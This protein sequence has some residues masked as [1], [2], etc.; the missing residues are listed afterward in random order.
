ML[1]GDSSNGYYR[2]G[3][4]R[5]VLY[6]PDEAAPVIF[7]VSSIGGGRAVLR[8]WRLLLGNYGL[9]GDEYDL[10]LTDGGPTFRKAMTVPLSMFYGA[11]RLVQPGQIAIGVLRRP[12][13]EGLD[14]YLKAETYQTFF[15]VDSGGTD[16]NRI[17]LGSLPP[18]DVYQEIPVEGYVERLPLG[19]V[20]S[21]FGNNASTAKKVLRHKLVFSFFSEFATLG[22]RT[23]RNENSVP[24]GRMIDDLQKMYKKG[25]LPG[26]RGAKEN[27]EPYD[28]YDATFKAYPMDRWFDILEPISLPMVDFSELG[29]GAIQIGYTLFDVDPTRIQFDLS[30]PMDNLPLLR[31]SGTL[32]ITKPETVRRWNLTAIFAGDDINTTLV[33]LLRQID[34]CPALPVWNSAFHRAGID[35]VVVE[36]VQVQTVEGYPNAVQVMLGGIEFHLPNSNLTPSYPFWMGFNW[37]LFKLYTDYMPRFAPMDMPWTGE[38]VFKVPSLRYVRQ[39]ANELRRKLMVNE[40]L[41]LEIATAKTGVDPQFH[42]ELLA[43][44]S[45]RGEA[46]LLPLEGG[47]KY[48]AW[49]A[50]SPD[51]FRYSILNAVQP[52]DVTVEP[53]PGFGRVFVRKREGNTISTEPL[54]P[55]QVSKLVQEFESV[56]QQSQMQRDS[57]ARAQANDR[58]RQLMGDYV[59]TLPETDTGPPVLSQLY[60]TLQRLAAQHAP[61]RKPEGSASPELESGEEEAES[62]KYER[63]ELDGVTVQGISCGFTNVVA[64]IE[65][66]AGGI[67]HQFLGHGDT[68]AV[69]TGVALPHGVRRL[70]Q[71]V[72]GYRA[73][74]FAFRGYGILSRLDVRL[75]AENELLRMMGIESVIPVDL[76]L[77]TMEGIPDTYRFTLVLVS[78]DPG[79]STREY[80]Q[81]LGGSEFRTFERQG[82]FSRR[83]R[84][85]DQV[86]RLD[87]G[88][89]LYY[90]NHINDAIA[91]QEVYPDLRLPTYQEV[92]SWLDAL[93]TKSV[94]SAEDR[95][96][97]IPDSVGLFVRDSLLEIYPAELLPTVRDEFLRQK[98]A[99]LVL[100]TSPK[101][102]NRY[103]DPDFFYSTGGVSGKLAIIKQLKPRVYGSVTDGLPFQQPLELELRGADGLKYR[104]TPDELKVF[105][106]QSDRISQEAV[107]NAYREA[108]MRTREALGMPTTGDMVDT[109]VRISLRPWEGSP[110]PGWFG[111]MARPAPPPNL[112]YVE[113]LGDPLSDMVPKSIAAA[114]WAYSTLVS[115]QDLVMPIIFVERIGSQVPYRVKIPARPQEKQVFQSMTPNEW[116]LVLLLFQLVENRGFNPYAIS[117]AGAKGLPQAMDQTWRSRLMALG[118]QVARADIVGEAGETRFSWSPAW[119]E[120]PTALG[121]VHLAHL[122]M[123][124]YI[125]DVLRQRQ[126]RIAGLVREALRPTVAGSPD[127]YRRVARVAAALW[128]PYNTGISG[129]SVETVSLYLEG[130]LAPA[131]SRTVQETRGGVARI[132]GELL[133]AARTIL[134]KNQGLTNSVIRFGAEGGATTESIIRTGPNRRLP[135]Q[136]PAESYTNEHLKKLDAIVKASSPSVK[137]LGAKDYKTGAGGDSWTSYRVWEEYVAPGLGLKPVEQLPNR[138][139]VQV[140]PGFDKWLAEQDRQREEAKKREEAEKKASGPVAAADTG[141]VA[142]VN[143][144]TASQPFAGWDTKGEFTT[145]DGPEHGGR[146]LFTT[147]WHD[148]VQYH[149]HGR[150]VAFFPAVFIAIVYGGRWVRRMRLWDQFYGIFGVASV[151]VFKSRKTPVHQAQIVL[152]NAYNALG[153][154]AFAHVLDQAI[155]RGYQSLEYSPEEQ[156]LGAGGALEQWWRNIVQSVFPHIGEYERT[157]YE[158]ELRSLFIRPGTRIH[159][160]MGYGADAGALPVVFNGT[161]GTVQFEDNLVNI[162]AL[163]DGVELDK[164]MR[165]TTV[166][167]KGGK[168]TQYYRFSGLFGLAVEPRQILVDTMTTT[169]RDDIPV[170]GPLIYAVTTG[171]Y[172]NGSTLGINNFGLTFMNPTGS[173]NPGETGVNLYN[174]TPFGENISSGMWGVADLF[175][176]MIP[177]WDAFRPGVR[178]SV[179]MANGSIWD[180]VNACRLSVLD[181]VAAV[182]PFDL[183]STLFVGRRDYPIYYTYMSLGEAAATYG[184]NWSESISI[185]QVHRLMRYK[186]FQQYH[187]VSSHDDLVSNR[188]SLSYE[189]VITDCAARDSSGVTGNMLMLDPMIISEDRREVV[190]DSVLNTSAINLILPGSS[191]ASWISWIFRMNPLRSTVG[192]RWGLAMPVREVNNVAANIIRDSLGDIYQGE[193]QIVGRASLK[194]YDLL[195]IVDEIRRMSGPVQV[196]EIHHHLSTQRGFL[197]IITPDL[198]TLGLN[199]KEYFHLYRFMAMAAQGVFDYQMVKNLYKVVSLRL[200]EEAGGLYSRSREVTADVEEYRRLNKHGRRIGELVTKDSFSKPFKALEQVVK[201]ANQKGGL[202]RSRRSVR[203]VLDWHTANIQKVQDILQEI[204]QDGFPEIVQDASVRR[205][206]Q[207]WL[208]QLEDDM[209]RLPD[210]VREAQQSRDELLKVERRFEVMERRIRDISA[211]GGKVEP[212]VLEEFAKLREQRNKLRT[213]TKLIEEEVEGILSRIREFHRRFPEV[214]RKVRIRMA[215]LLV[216]RLR[217]NFGDRYWKQVYTEAR[218]RGQ[219]ELTQKRMDDLRQLANE[220]AERGPVRLS[221]KRR[222]QLEQA[223]F[224]KVRGETAQT[225]RRW[226]GLRWIGRTAWQGVTWGP[227]VAYR[228]LKRRGVRYRPPGKIKLVARGMFTLTGRWLKGAALSVYGLFAEHPNWDRTAGNIFSRWW[229]TVQFRPVLQRSPAE[230]VRG[231]RSGF[232][233][234][235]PSVV[236]RSALILMG[237]GHLIELINRKINSVYVCGLA[238]LKSAG[239]PFLAGLRGH[240]GIV[241]GEEPGFWQ[242]LLSSWNP[243]YFEQKVLP[244]LN[245]SPWMGK[246]IQSVANAFIMRD[247]NPI[248]DLESEWD[249]DQID[250]Y[251]GDVA[252]GLMDYGM[253]QVIRGDNKEVYGEDIVRGAPQIRYNSEWELDRIRHSERELTRALQFARDIGSGPA[254][255]QLMPLPVGGNASLWVPPSDTALLG[256]LDQRAAR[257]LSRYLSAVREELNRRTNGQVGVYI[258][259]GRRP[260]ILQ[261]ALYASKSPDLASLNRRARADGVREFSPEEFRVYRRFYPKPNPYPVAKPGTSPHERGLAID[262]GF[263]TVSGRS[264]SG[265]SIDSY[266]QILDQVAARSEFRG[267]IRRVPGDPVHVEVILR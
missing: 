8:V 95:Y 119:E 241:V 75:I 205:E 140:P 162:A 166:E 264:V 188:V 118:A 216:F 13:T 85:E 197:S 144:G 54:T 163:G 151:D 37:P 99:G 234:L 104:M 249:W 67:I 243:T 131:I 262:V 72:E 136:R 24:R 123:I 105:G 31:A 120:F 218:G 2:T 177:G 17:T 59:F 169:R 147:G 253:L 137:V 150:L 12:G 6:A 222:Q 225:R 214:M 19:Y 90:S 260:L 111:E 192:E 187:M 10:G 204:R 196:K 133:G 16:P 14:S 227:R 27:L 84:P 154:A 176:L 181:Y 56:Y 213:E 142:A 77:E 47:R 165:P 30:Y 200:F 199:D 235:V 20:P 179:D 258:V 42:A 92:Q 89:V 167:S 158:L 210:A 220:E 173:P 185:N 230:L 127:W 106:T 160:R 247:R 32:K 219:G 248:Q 70:R 252:T 53:V 124:H 43:E 91:A 141:S 233:R 112:L 236:T 82:P 217:A 267:V 194:P 246:A 79:Q 4:D 121:S 126:D 159:I 189:G 73:L 109:S 175:A 203:G 145:E 206:L 191:N 15:A 168:S 226:R 3:D 190:V 238:P 63:V 41:I 83:S 93:T 7:K 40:N 251:E 108:S 113:G 22:L 161:I 182:E 134:S 33:P 261:R 130:A 183:R 207:G 215:R 221:E 36:S 71:M 143:T 232:R 138:R 148:Y 266:S 78:F 237:V 193:I 157:V 66:E 129:Y 69:V 115:G 265:V 100:P 28:P 132:T 212:S 184:S 88:S 240:A 171:S 180:L 81:R 35:A 257:T 98:E 209:A 149:H 224:K 170:L 195:F 65:R 57:R 44:S 242:R 107:L 244:N 1:A 146:D 49:I 38:L 11:E 9:V 18:P 25:R 254:P 48:Y 110:P 68:V 229:R 208:Y 256:H 117:K 74:A 239:K 164:P 201:D 45:R 202:F 135:E 152:A 26:Y 52:E 29:D 122:F 139:G 156:F 5:L 97:E 174:S 76:T 23:V 153:N 80:V 62:G 103:V 55:D 128:I 102:R 125:V 211:A 58:L 51:Q 178:I 259:S 64:S 39:L 263:Y 96:D 87:V 250:L 116:M 94:M 114:V 34:R 228:I 231:L 186:Q 46:I 60:R 223:I 172:L 101:Y 245:V 50:T 155:A 198:V 61:K 255:Y 86:I 21:Q